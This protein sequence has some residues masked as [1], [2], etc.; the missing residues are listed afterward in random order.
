ML[1]LLVIFLFGITGFTINHE[2]WFGA[3]DPRVNEVSGRT[4][5]ALIAKRDNL[6]IVEQL[7]KTFLISGAVTSF[8]E[9]GEEYSLTFKQPGE[10]WEIVIKKADG[11]TSVHHEMFNFAAIINNLHRGR[12]SGGAWHWVIDLSSLLIVLACVTGF[13]LW[14]ALPKRRR[15]GVIYLTLGA[16][17]TLAVVYFLV[18]GPDINLSAAPTEAPAAPTGP[19]AS[20]P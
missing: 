10:I 20:S 7:R 5:A 15:L 3:T 8:E 16:A 18:P 13:I 2:D 14:L 12:Y 11:Q 6:A 4:P 9:F 19:R 1:G 17:G